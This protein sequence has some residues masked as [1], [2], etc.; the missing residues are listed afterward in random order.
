MT[1]EQKKQIENYREQFEQNCKNYATWGSQRYCR[2]DLYK[3]ESLD[4]PNITIVATTITDISDNYEPYVKTHNLMIE[5]DGNVINL[6]DVFDSSQ[7][8][9]YIEKLKKVD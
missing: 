6:F 1:T 4:D 7:V 2:F 3:S 9:S 5:P 8:M